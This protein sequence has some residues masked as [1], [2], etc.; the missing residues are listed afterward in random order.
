M[1]I[2]LF[3]SASKVNPIGLGLIYSEESENFVNEIVPELL[4]T[5]EDSFDIYMPTNMDTEKNTIWSIYALNKADFVM[6][7]ITKTDEEGFKESIRFLS[8]YVKHPSMKNVYMVVECGTVL[9]NEEF[10]QTIAVL[11]ND[12]NNEG[13]FMPVVNMEEAVKVIGEIVKGVS[14]LSF[15]SIT[16]ENGEEL[17]KESIEECSCED[18][19]YDKEETIVEE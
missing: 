19:G 3:N 16:N 13:L 9:E 14:D 5:V 12:P 17:T 1:S 2:R 11:A 6:T 7:N 18:C 8:E 15:F 4:T 10:K